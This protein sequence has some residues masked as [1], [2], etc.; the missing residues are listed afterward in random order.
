MNASN[1][2]KSFNYDQYEFH[3]LVDSNYSFLVMT[4]KGYKMRIA[5]ACLEDLKNSFFKEFPPTARDGAIA[6]G[7][8]DQFAPVLFMLA[9]LYRYRKLR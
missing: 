3:I 6:Y 5:F 7:L 1:V 8:N 4:E 9:T 2:K